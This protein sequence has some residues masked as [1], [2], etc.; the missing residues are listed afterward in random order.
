MITKV[1]S[2][3]SSTITYRDLLDIF[4]VAIL[5]YYLFLLIK[6]T[7]AVQILQGVGVLLILLFISYKL[8]LQTIYW[9]LHYSLYGFVVAIP[10]VFQPELRRALGFLGRGGGI[11][12]A[13][14]RVHREDLTKMID[15]IVWTAAIFSQSKTGA[16]MVIERETGLEEFIETGTR[17]NGEVSAKLLLSIFNTKSPLHDGAVI[18][19]ADKI[20]A[21]SCYLPLSE[22]LMSSQ[23]RSYGTRHRAALG[24]SE[25]TDAIVIIISEETGNISIARNGKFTKNL[26]EETLKKVLLTFYPFQFASAGDRAR[27]LQGAGAKNAIDAFF[28]KQ[29][30]T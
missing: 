13:F 8:N 3:L 7:R 12:T 5:L 15:D 27:K 18:V 30:G 19:R 10:I 11:K 17:L 1:L 9:L 22:N 2:T 16:L 6:G 26:T 14:G 29:P 25:Q 23:G 24:L 28:K 21:A 20:V 4:F